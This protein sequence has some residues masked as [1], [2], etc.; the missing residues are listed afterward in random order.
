MKPIQAVAAV[1]A[2]TAAGKTLAGE[3]EDLLPK[4]GSDNLNERK[5]G[6]DRFEDLVLASGKP[7]AEA[8]RAAT[9][10][11]ICALLEKEM[12]DDT[13]CWLL[14]ELWLIGGAEA[15]PTLVKHLDHKGTD[16]ADAARRAL[17]KNSAPEATAALVAAL[18]K[19]NTP[20]WKVA[21]LIALGGRADSKATSAVAQHLSDKDL[22]VVSAAAAALGQ[23][24]CPDS[25]K[26]LAAARKK[27][28][29]EQK[30]ILSDRYLQVAEN[31]LRAG[32]YAE[33]LAI[34]KE[35]DSTSETEL[36]R[37]AARQGQLAVELS[38][39]A[40]PGHLIYQEVKGQ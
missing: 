30:A 38:K 18:G 12:S 31:W 1:A 28:S 16:V 26:A 37:V 25:A 24:A 33:A 36:V 19:A 27:G 34:Y 13:R 20:E 23:I 40:G 21:C 10:K 5:S 11:A 8:E 14:R 39:K 3:L 7:G 9:S 17:Q 29:A 4:I 6:R 22:S 15:I 32:K 35:L 2:A